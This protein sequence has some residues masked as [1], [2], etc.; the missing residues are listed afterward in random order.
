[1]TLQDFINLLPDAKIQTISFDFDAKNI[2]HSQDLVIIVSKLQEQIEQY[3]L[4][5]SNTSSFNVRVI[6]S[7][8]KHTKLTKVK[9]LRKP[10]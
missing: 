7:N 10:I 5:F 3:Q 1:M 6:G 4:V 8:M 9:K 2:Q